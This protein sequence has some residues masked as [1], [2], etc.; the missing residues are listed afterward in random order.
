MAK[1]PK[2]AAKEIYDVIEWDDSKERVV[3]IATVEKDVVIQYNDGTKHRVTH[4]HLFTNMKA[5]KVTGA[6]A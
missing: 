5:E 1:K 3:V 2:A 6:V 4:A